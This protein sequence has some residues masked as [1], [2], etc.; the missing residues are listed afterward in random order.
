MIKE[1]IFDVETQRLFNELSTP[2]PAGLGLSVVS[3]Y[4]RQLNNSFE[5]TQ[6]ELNTFWEKDLDNL[7]GLFQSADRIIGFNSVHFDVPVL[8]PY[9][10]LPLAKFN[11]FDILDKVKESFGKRISLNALASQTLNSHKTDV[12]TNAVVYWKK[13][14]PES[15]NKL[16]KYCEA[17]VLLTKDLYDYALSNKQL[18]FLDKWNTLRTIDVDFSYPLQELSKDQIGL[19]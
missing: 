17:D 4:S 16:Q 18:K 19:F 10:T 7:W 2:D 3:A 11:H 13:G 5:E 8:Q 14:D 15:L 6:G 1:V 12:G 9:T